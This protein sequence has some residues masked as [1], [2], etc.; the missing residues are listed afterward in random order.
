MQGWLDPNHS[1]PLAAK[2]FLKCSFFSSSAYVE[3]EGGWS[4]YPPQSSLR[5]FFWNSSMVT[6]DLGTLYIP[7]EL[8]WIEDNVFLVIMKG[9]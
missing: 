8:L 5:L 9:V 2:D 1:I 6:S 7:F 4:L 3:W